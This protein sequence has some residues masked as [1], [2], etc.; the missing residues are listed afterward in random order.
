MPAGITD[1]SRTFRE[2]V[3]DWELVDGRIG[4]R[5]Q[6]DLA[7]TVT[8]PEGR[9]RWDSMCRNGGKDLMM[10]YSVEGVPGWIG[11]GCGPDT[12]LGPDAAD[13]STETVGTDPAPRNRPVEVR[14]WLGPTDGD[15]QEVAE[16]ADVLLGLAVYRLD[17]SKVDVLGERLDAT[18]E[19]AGHTWDVT[20]VRGV[21]GDEGRYELGLPASPTARV[22]QIVVRHATDR[23]V[24]LRNG[25]SGS[26]DDS[27]RVVSPGVG[28]GA[29]V[30]GPL[31]VLPGEERTV[32][33]RF[34]KGW[35]PDARVTVVTSVLAD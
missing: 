18:F 14:I 9:L 12:L 5:G 15:P 1:G 33:L 34:R 27:I 19:A 13:G 31:L 10:K 28:T 29:T 7:F 24:E 4:E 11:S 26:E 3:A 32:T 35:T 23:P 21:A 30:L 25:V 20:G 22:V 2:E 8:L 16:D 6:T 17:G